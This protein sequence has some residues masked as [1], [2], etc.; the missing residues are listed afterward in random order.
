MTRPLVLIVFGT[1]P[2]AIKMCPVVKALEAFP[3]LQVKICVTGQ[4]REML[5]QVLDIF[6]ITADD[7]LH[8]MEHDQSLVALTARMLLKMQAVIEER[9][10]ALI[11]VHGDT[12]TSMV[13]SLASYYA[14]IPVGHVEAGL[15]TGNKLQPFPEEVN[16][17]LTAVL[18][19]LH[20][21]PTEQAKNNLLREGI[22]EQRIKVTGNTVIDALYGMVRRI[23]GDLALEAVLRSKFAMV[24]NYDKMVLITG[25]RRESFGQGFENICRAVV[26]LADAHPEVVFIY[27]VHLNPHVRRPVEKIVG[28]AAR[29]NIF[30]IEPVDYISF[31]A[32]LRRCYLVLTDSGGIQEEAPALGKPVVVMRATT[33]RP[34]AVLAGTVELAGSDE[35]QIVCAV[36]R[37]LADRDRYQRMS[38]VSTAYGDGQAATR[39]ATHISEFLQY[40]EA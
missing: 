30:L 1:R 7:E 4:H 27:P 18:A 40:H 16:R 33:E 9:R 11:L 31:V 36:S 34:E 3:Q 37:L 32:L 17:R 23:D 2:E 19:D 22:V 26:R 5:D 38:R 8:I 29:R 35:E 12:T 39:I 10:P 21:A 24:D 20:F 6:A 25:H 15:R 13:A 14:G 28:A